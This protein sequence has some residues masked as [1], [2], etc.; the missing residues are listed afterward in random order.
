MLYY[1]GVISQ[2][3]IFILHSGTTA[4]GTTSLLPYKEEHG[5]CVL[6]TKLKILLCDLKLNPD[7]RK[8]CM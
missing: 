2:L 3:I 6:H 1:V 4:Y 8:E 5:H 7:E